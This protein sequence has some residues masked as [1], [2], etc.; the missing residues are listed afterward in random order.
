MSTEVLVIEYLIIGIILAVLVVKRM[1]KSVPFESVNPEDDY[2]QR[3]ARRATMVTALIFAT[4]LWP[5]FIVG[6]FIRIVKKH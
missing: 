6:E 2:Y 3:K 1:E 4:F 5:L